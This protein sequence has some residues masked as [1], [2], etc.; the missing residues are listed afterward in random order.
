[1]GLFHARCRPPEN[2]YGR[3]DLTVRE[4]EVVAFA[5]G[6]VADISRWLAFR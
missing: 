6:L 4:G 3:A 1:M 2:R 5:S